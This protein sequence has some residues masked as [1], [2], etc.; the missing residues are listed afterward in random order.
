MFLYVVKPHTM[1][2]YVVEVQL[3]LFL[4]R[5]LYEESDIDNNQANSVQTVEHNTFV[6][7]KTH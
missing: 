3:Q 6:I 5:V 7:Y 2:V 4:T 1:N